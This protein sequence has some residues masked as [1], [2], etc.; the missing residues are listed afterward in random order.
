MDLQPTQSGGEIRSEVGLDLLLKGV[1]AFL[2]RRRKQ[3][4]FEE[5][6][7]SRGEPGGWWLAGLKHLSREVVVIERFCRVRQN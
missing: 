6:L 4:A 3:Q 1:G 7:C 2:S 5:G